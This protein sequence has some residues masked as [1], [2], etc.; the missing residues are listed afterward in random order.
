VPRQSCAALLLIAAL[1]I[2]A[3][4]IMCVFPFKW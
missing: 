2:V 3:G 4:A 1:C